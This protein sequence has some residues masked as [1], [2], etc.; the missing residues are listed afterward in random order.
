MDDR[1][2]SPKRIRND[3]DDRPRRDS[4]TSRRGSRANDCETRKNAMQ[5]EKKRGK[6]LFGGLLS[7]LSQ[8]SGNTQQK[9]RREIEQRQQERM[10]KQRAEDDKERAVKR[11]SLTEIRMAEQIVFDEEV[12]SSCRILPRTCLIMDTDAQQALQDTRHR[13]IPTDEIR[14]ANREIAPDSGFEDIEEC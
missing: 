11:A 10:R 6:R 7:T 5:E 13:T 2:S 8:T 3:A 9:R 12:V 1:E 14:T 4:S